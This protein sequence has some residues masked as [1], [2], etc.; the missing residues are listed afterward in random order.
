MKKLLGI[1]VLTIIW[2]SDGYAEE[3]KCF[4]KNGFVTK[5]YKFQKKINFKDPSN[6]LIFIYNHG[7]S[8]ERSVSDSKNCPFS[9][10]NLVNVLKLTKEDFGAKK[11][12]LYI[13]NTQALYGDAYKNRKNKTKWVA[14][15]SG[16]YSGKTKTE[17]KMDVMNKIIDNFYKMGIKPENIIISGKSCGGWLTLMYVARHPEKVRGGIAYHPACFDRLTEFEIW[18]A[19]G[20]WDYFEDHNWKCPTKDKYDGEYAC[21]RA[22]FNLR[23]TNITEIGNAKDLKVV[24]VHNEDDPYEGKTSKWLKNIKSIELIET[25]TKEDNYKINGKSCI[26]KDS[27]KNKS[28]GHD[29]FSSSCMPEFFPRIVKYFK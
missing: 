13:V 27:K 7:D 25:P 14:Y 3:F 11:N 23:M 8:G 22:Y 17:K 15:P 5:G 6:T 28:I 9:K 24:V 1:L 16:P 19:D 12:Y 10:R 21:A 4:Y 26:A 2:C 18:T 29:V 20:K